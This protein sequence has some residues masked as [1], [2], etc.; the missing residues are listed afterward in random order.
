MP[1]EHGQLHEAPKPPEVVKLSLSDL[2]EAKTLLTTL[3]NPGEKFDEQ[4]AE[5]EFE[6]N[7]E[8]VTEEANPGGETLNAMSK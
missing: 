2:E 4:K 5:A 7:F 8:Q 6:K 3:P 1:E